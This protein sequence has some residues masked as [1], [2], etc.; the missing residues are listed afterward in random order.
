MDKPQAGNDQRWRGGAA[1]SHRHESN[2]CER[3]TSQAHS[4]ANPPRESPLGLLPVQRSC[5]SKGELVSPNQTS[6]VSCK[7]CR[8]RAARRSSLGAST[9]L[10]GAQ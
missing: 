1:A 6:T 4:T 5:A 2:D 7:S 9:V 3:N 8:K 10:I